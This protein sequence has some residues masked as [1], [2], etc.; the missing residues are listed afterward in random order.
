MASLTPPKAVLKAPQPNMD[1]MGQGFINDAVPAPQAQPT[2]YGVNSQPINPAHDLRSQQITPGA[3]PR[4]SGA[5]GQTDTARGNL[6]ASTFSPYAPVSSAGSPYTA[7][8]DRLRGASESALG[9]G[10]VKGTDTSAAQGLLN[11]AATSYGASGGVSGF[12]GYGA[13]TGA[14][15]SAL[16]GSL[17]NLQGPDRSKLAADA[18]KLLQEQQAPGRAMDYQN[19][20]RKA[21]ALGRVGAGMTT[22]DLT[23]LSQSYANADDQAARGLAMDAAG[24]TLN[25]RLGITN[26]LSG[27]AGQLSGLDQGAAGLNQSASLANANL[28]NSRGSSFAN[29]AGDQLALSQVPHNEQVQD[30]A[31]GLDRSSALSGLSKDAFNTGSS[32]RN[33]ARGEG[34]RRLA[35]DQANLAKNSGIYNDLAGGEQQVFNQGQATRNEIRGERSNQQDQTQQ[36]IDNG[37]KQRMAEEDLLNSGAQRGTNLTELYNQLGYG[38]QG[39]LENV[40]GGQAQDANAQSDAAF[41]GVGDL[42]A[43][44]LQGQ[45]A[46]SAAVKYATSG[47]TPNVKNTAQTYRPVTLANAPTKFPTYQGP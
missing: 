33:E 37:L 26:T 28:A 27:V 34:D 13:D 31:Y 29:L 30:R 46:K 39:D 21:A 40:L 42:L 32:L 44:Y 14:A 15:R 6:A 23:G 7:D 41:G 10:A 22:N 19:V 43:Q 9:T 45:G 1:P 24:Q 8:A 4:L 2:A 16:T 35:Y 11:K 38:G 17:A 25:D 20:G 12:G 5:Q 18:F 36:G 3:D 47:M